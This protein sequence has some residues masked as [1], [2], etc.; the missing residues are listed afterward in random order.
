[1]QLKCKK[2]KN[3]CSV[4]SRCC[5]WL[6]EHV[7]SGLRNFMLEIFCW[8]FLTPRSGRPVEV[9]SYQINTLLQNNQRYTMQKITDILKISKSST[10][11]HLHHALLCSS[12]WCLGSTW[13]KQK[14]PLDRISACDSLLKRNEN[15]PFL[16]Q[17]VLRDEKWMLYNNVEWKRPWGKGN[18]PPST[19]PKASLHPKKVMLCIR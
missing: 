18:V 13:F 12:L 5:L 17:I 7:K 8:R 4:W 14:K 9:D 6:I 19:T 10:E 11:N 3:L 16:K 2:K 1:M 15:V